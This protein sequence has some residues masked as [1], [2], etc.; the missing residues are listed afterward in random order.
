MKPIQAIFPGRS[1]I[2]S[3]WCKKLLKGMPEPF[4]L[5]FL[6]FF[7]LLSALY[8]FPSLGVNFRVVKSKYSHMAVLMWALQRTWRHRF[9]WISS[10][11]ALRIWSTTCMLTFTG[12]LINKGRSMT[13]MKS[14]LNT[15]LLKK[16]KR[17]DSS[18]YITF[19]KHWA[20]VS[21]VMLFDWQAS[22]TFS[23]E[24]ED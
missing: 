14:L 15:N 22:V 24:R 13:F 6:S 20:M 18:Y 8:F 12:M 1:P 17:L 7:F 2:E 23:A 10:K 5:P 3:R 16:E 9:A 19:S 21:I 4:F 11:Q